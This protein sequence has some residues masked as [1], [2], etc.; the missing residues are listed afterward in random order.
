VTDRAVPGSLS[1]RE[2][3]EIDLLA[4][5]RVLGGASGLDR[6][7]Q[8]LNVM[9]VPDIVR[10]TKEREL[11]LT[12]GYPL[13]DSPPELIRLFT[14][15]DARGVAAVGVKYG[16]YGPGLMPEALSAADDLGLPIIDIPEAVAFDDLLGRVLSDI[17][18][19]QAAALAHAQQIHDALLQI[20]LGGGGLGDIVRE[21]GAALGGAGVICLDTTGRVLEQVAGEDHWERIRRHD[22]LDS[23]GSVA[24]GRLPG[25]VHAE[26]GLLAAS[27]P[28]LAGTLRHGH[29]LAVAGRTPLP[30][31]AQVMVQQSAM[32]A[33][34]EITQRLAVSAVERHFESNA[35]HELLTG[36]E[37]GVEDVLSRAASF[38]WR[39]DR[40]LLV[41]VARRDTDG[42]EPRQR[43]DTDAWISTVRSMD[44]LAVAG[45]L[46]RDLVAVCGADGTAESVARAVADGIRGMMRSSFS[47]GASRVVEAPRELPAA[48][49]HA[50]TALDIAQRT[51]G[52]G[53]VMPYE[54][55]GLYRLL[56]AVRDRAELR[57][58]VDE[59]L[60]AVLA[61]PAGER[62]DLLRTL[63]VLLDTHLNVA[64]SARLLH[65][66]YNTM[67]Y[68]IR[69]LERL[70]GPF[71]CDPR[72]CLRLA[73]ALQILQMWELTEHG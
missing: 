70:A 32:V 71:T 23:D 20:F 11:L 50:R 60:G 57:A 13:P 31:Q 21:L 5:A 48:Y 17:T 24:A 55:L 49:R 46:G 53:T 18:N 7:V 36:G 4:D 40:P 54:D 65:F 59:T 51:G 37:R 33:A 15:L 25:A 9:T 61:R 69:K 28:V 35:I 47:I 8:R 6:R 52:P 63:R 34:L 3:L 67:R 62:D 14:E 64:E 26:G 38:G 39:L 73:V 42:G 43:H 44:K 56:T 12:T 45:R 10:W 16:A 1:V 58:F 19:R 27:A 68:R 72:L 66:H 29:L 2:I 22:L 41:L 30:P